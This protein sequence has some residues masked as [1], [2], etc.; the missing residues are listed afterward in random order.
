MVTAISATA[1]VSAV[2][3]NTATV[4]ESASCHR[5]S[6]SHTSAVASSYRYDATTAVP[7]AM[8]TVTV[9]TPVTNNNSLE[10]RPGSP[11]LSLSLPSVGR[12]KSSWPWPPRAPITLSTA[13]RKIIG[14][15]PLLPQQLGAASRGLACDSDPHMVLRLVKHP[16]PPT[17]IVCLSLPTCF[18]RL[19][20]R[21]VHGSACLSD[22]C[23]TLVPRPVV[24]TLQVQ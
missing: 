11:F 3:A 8:A 21:T 19:P 23:G 7:I 12:R 18:L 14:E 17:L 20:E 1:V 15:S 22:S 16:L 9:N 6:L 24:D 2:A 4:T 5:C 10:G 13:G